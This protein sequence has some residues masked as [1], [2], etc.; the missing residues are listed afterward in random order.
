MI[1]PEKLELHC[2][3]LNNE[4]GGKRL[5][6]SGNDLSFTDLVG[7]NLQNANL[8]ETNISN[9]DLTGANLAGANL[10]NANL[11]NTD[12][13]SANLANANMRNATLFLADLTNANL[14]NTDFTGADLSYAFG[15]F[16]IGYFG[17]HHAI[18]A[19][20]Y[21]SI[22]CR[23]LTYAE[24]MKNGAKV[25]HSNGYST[26]DIGWYLMW[27][28]SA[29]EWLVSEAICD[30]EK[31]L[32]NPDPGIIDNA[33]FIVRTSPPYMLLD[34]VEALANGNPGHLRDVIDIVKADMADMKE[35]QDAE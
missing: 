7:I 18:A 27:A 23:R 34:W 13:T 17:R 4:P 8:H 26:A 30:L 3:W 24:W 32:E 20:G 21:I 33:K 6:L 2:K 5:D 14:T 25:G 31:Q 1:T 10:S 29:A 11:S 16:A 9:A 15:K 12:L 19:G 22:G 35:D 28:E